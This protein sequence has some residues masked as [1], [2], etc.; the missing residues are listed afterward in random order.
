MKKK[1]VLEQQKSDSV[2]NNNDRKYTPTQIMKRRDAATKIQNAYRIFL[3]RIDITIIRYTRYLQKHWYLERIYNIIVSKLQNP[4]ENF[5]HETI[6]TND[7]NDNSIPATEKILVNDT[8]NTHINY[9]DDNSNKN[10]NDNTKENRG[11][12][13]KKEGKKLLH[14]GGFLQ[15][16]RLLRLMDNE[17][18][19]TYLY[20]IFHQ[21]CKLTADYPTSVA[22]ISNT[23]KISSNTYIKDFKYYD[24]LK[25]PKE[26]SWL[27]FLGKYV[28]KQQ[29]FHGG[30]I[31]SNFKYHTETKLSIE[32]FWLSIYC[33][34]YS[35]M[36]VQYT[37]DGPQEAVQ[38]FLQRYVYRSAEEVFVG[39]MTNNNDNG[40]S[41]NLQIEEGVKHENDEGTSVVKIEKEKKWHDET[42]YKIFNFEEMLYDSSEKF[43]KEL[44][45]Y[46]RSMRIVFC[47]YA[48]PYFDYPEKQE[49]YKY[50]VER[51]LD[52]M[53]IYSTD[54]DEQIWLECLCSPKEYVLS[55]K[56]FTRILIGLGLL[57]EEDVKGHAKAV[58]CFASASTR[59]SVGFGTSFTKREHSL[60]PSLYRTKQLLVRD[61]E[62][63]VL[64]N[65]KKNAVAERICRCGRGFG[66]PPSTE[67]KMRDLYFLNHEL[68][69]SEKYALQLLF[70]KL[71]S[72]NSGFLDHHEIEQVA[73]RFAG[74]ERTVGEVYTCLRILDKDNDGRVTIHEL[75]RTIVLA[76]ALHRQIKAC[77]LSMPEFQ[78]AFSLYVIYCTIKTTRQEMDMNNADYFQSKMKSLTSKFKSLIGKEMI[79][80][81]EGSLR[82]QKEMEDLGLPKLIDPELP[83][84]EKKF[85]DIV[86]NHIHD[87]YCQIEM[88]AG[89]HSF[90]ALETRGNDN[91]NIKSEDAGVQMKLKHEIQAKNNILFQDGFN[92]FISHSKI[93]PRITE[94]EKVACFNIGVKKQYSRRLNP[95]SRR[96]GLLVSA[97]NYSRS[98]TM[99]KMNASA[100]QRNN[101]T[102]TP[103][104]HGI[105]GLNMN[106]MKLAIKHVAFLKFV[107]DCFRKGQVPFIGIYAVDM[108]IADATEN[109]LEQIYYAT[110]IKSGKIKS[111]YSDYFKKMV[112]RLNLLYIVYKPPRVFGINS[113]LG[114][115]HFQTKGPVWKDQR[116]MSEIINNVN[117]NT[118]RSNDQ[119]IDNRNDSTGWYNNKLVIHEKN[120]LAKSTRYSQNALA[121]YQ[122]AINVLSD[123]QT[124]ANS[125]EKFINEEGKL[126]NRGYSVTNSKYDDISP[127]EMVRNL[128][129]QEESERF[130]STKTTAMKKTKKTGG[131]KKKKGRGKKKKKTKG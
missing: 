56:Q 47:K 80:V 50:D 77:T 62:D 2:G 45:F 113:N 107:N 49:V 1:T 106:G 128:K 18:N 55:V 81:T 88:S 82:R 78:H 98:I 33:L 104:L 70:S 31:S 83:E 110:Y 112:E 48:T 95:R 101:I 54:S 66:P 129:I 97:G 40:S 14:F 102:P 114:A 99:E 36:P 4:N 41:E 46:E 119:H 125:F 11:I 123:N 17:I 12:T 13:K 124:L 118:S 105:D 63:Y 34:T 3:A 92:N 69:E 91:S 103:P 9:N 115:S 61:I 100:N 121:Y 27:S 7:N 76:N 87:K 72:D 21:C 57:S 29:A 90:E 96:T 116:Y 65:N 126:S 108:D 42:H 32:G 79:E 37:R 35:E 60:Y 120:R 6:V 111:F 28:C 30:N 25:R 20:G 16:V 127:T 22:E 93:Y 8:K 94:E 109:D 43:S 59:Q 85:H 52:E 73:L 67:Q 68:K 74:P 51:A 58:C 122:N 26:E 24:T 64:D 117:S 5:I 84:L 44:L 23:L 39:V 71:D 86:C 75:E 38:T 130:L 89:T 53:D 19:H 131:G 10:S 15:F